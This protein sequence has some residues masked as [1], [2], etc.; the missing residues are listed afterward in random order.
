MLYGLTGA[1]RAGKTTTAQLVAETMGIEFYPTSTSALAKQ[2]GVN[3]VGLMRVADRLDFQT[4]VLDNHINMIETLP[5][6][7]ITDRTPL[8]FLSYML[9]EFGMTSHEQNSSAVLD[10]VRRYTEMCFE[11]AVK[12]YDS[13]Y[14]LPPLETYHSEAGK[15]A[16]NWPY[17]TNMSLTLLGALERARCNGLDISYIEDQN[18][19]TRAEFICED[20]ENRVNT[21]QQIRESS[22]LH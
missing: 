4:R 12:Y 22:S 1:H 16:E 11:V 7:L 3:P 19:N 21:I 20:I 8:D 18:L 17:Q 10:G 15:P 14:Y 6:P 13:I 5:R 2:L 9:C